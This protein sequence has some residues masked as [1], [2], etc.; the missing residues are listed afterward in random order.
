MIGPRPLFREG[1]GPAD[2]WEM[3]IHRGVSKADASAHVLR[4]IANT[5]EKVREQYLKDVDPGALASFGLGMADMMSFGLGDQV[6]RKLD[7]EVTRAGGESNQAALTQEAAKALHGTA[8]TVGEVAGALTPIGIEM[9]LSKA[10]VMAPMALT[11][12]VQ[13]I[14]SPVGRALAKTALSATEGAA[15]AAAQGAGREEGSLGE[16]AVAGAKMAP[17]GAVVGAALPYAVPT[18]MV[19]LDRLIARP[20]K[21][22]GRIAGDILERRAGS[23][24]VP[25]DLPNIKMD[26]TPEGMPGLKPINRPVAPMRDPLDVPT[27][28]RREPD[29]VPPGIMNIKPSPLGPNDLM[30]P[31]DMSLVS[32][33]PRPRRLPLV[34]RGPFPEPRGLESAATG[35]ADDYLRSGDLAQLDR[36]DPAELVQRLNEIGGFK[37]GQWLRVREYLADWIEYLGRGRAGT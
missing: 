37:P 36:F 21:Y 2:L 26:L 20:A 10:G 34:Q 33:Q 30:P 13:A 31:G 29:Y 16:R 6:A 18:A 27:F 1:F 22:V 15:Y 14:Q 7:E 25:R 23:R 12:F 8:H 5:P 9:G 28:I 17:V 32:G 4:A 11:K 24:V 35:A 3:L 19:A